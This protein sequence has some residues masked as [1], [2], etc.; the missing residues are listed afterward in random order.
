MPKVGIGPIRRRQLIEA[1]IASISRHGF[2]DTTVATIAKEA[3]VSTGI[4]HHYFGDKN[5]LLEA[6]MRNLLEDLRVAVIDRLSRARTPRER[7]EAIIDGNFAPEQFEG[8]AVAGWLALW[9]Q[10]PHDPALGRLRRTNTRR[11]RSNIRHALRP[12]LPSEKVDDAAFGLAAMIDGLW[13]HCALRGGEFRTDLARRTAREYLD[14]MLT[15]G[16]A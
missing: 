14:S 8:T 2:V 12:L 6:T 9:A 16:K 13:L 15:Q 4:V 3:G 1:T 10:S 11:L 5:R 7:A